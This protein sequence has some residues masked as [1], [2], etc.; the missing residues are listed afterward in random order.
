MEI[1]KDIAEVNNLYEVS[2]LGRFKRK[3]RGGY[4]EKILKL[5]YYS[6]GYLQFSVTINRQR[7]T[8]I[9]HRIVAKYFV[10]NDKPEIYNIVNHI[11]G[12][13]D[14]NRSENLEWC[15]QSMN[16]KHSFEKLGRLPKDNKGIKNPKVLL[17][18]EQ[19]IT[20]RKLYNEG[21]KQKELCDIFNVKYPVIYKIIHRINWK[22]I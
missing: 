9:S 14:D 1:W 19:V 12:I 15:T 21:V 11:N 8:A 10:K 13:K 16:N 6:N 7:Y 18:E 4:C 22:H 20:I 5:A 17:N 2:N 3:K